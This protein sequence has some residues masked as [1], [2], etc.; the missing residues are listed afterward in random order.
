MQKK[1]SKILSALL[2]VFLLLSMMPTQVFAATENPWNSSSRTDNVFLDA[3]KYLGYNTTR[4]TQYNEVGGDVA[5]SNRT[6]IG[7]NTGGATG[8]ETSAGLP[9]IATFKSKGLCCGSYA[10]YVYFNYLPNVAKVD[11]KKFT[12]PSNPRSTTSWHEACEKWVTAGN[13]KKTTFNASCSSIS[14][15]S[16][17]QSLP[18]GTLLIFKDS[19]GAYLHT[20]IYAG[21]RTT[22]NYT[23]YYQTHVGN[24]R[25]PEVCLIN[26][27]NKDGK[28]ATLEATYT[29]DIP[30]EYF[31]AVGIKKVDDLGKAVSG[32]KIGLYSD[33]GCTKLVTTLT[34]GSDG[35]ATY[36]YSNG[37][38]TLEEG[39]TYYFKEISAPSGYDISTTVVSVKV[40]KEKITYA[41]TSIVDNRQGKITLTKYDDAGTKLGAGYVFG[42]YSDK[43]CTKQV[44]T[45]TT[46]ANSVATS[47]Y[48]SAG[49]YY[50][51]EK[52]LPSSDKTHT[53]NSTVYTVTVTKGGTTAVNN[54]RFVNDRMKG[55][56][57]IVKTSPDGN[58]EG[59]G[60]TVTGNGVNQT[61]KTGADGTITLSNLTAGTYTVKENV[62]EGYICK[63]ATKTVTVSPGATATVTFENR[64]IF[65]NI[66]LTKVDAE[67][68]D[69]KLSGAEFTVTIKKDGKTTTQKMMEVSKGVYRL[70]N[71][72][73]GSVCTVKE[74]V[75]PEGFVLSDET[76]TVT[77]KEE[78]TYT[79]NSAGFGC[80]INR[81]IKGSLKIVKVDSF[82]KTPLEDVG[83][84]L[85]DSSG[86]QIKEGYTD[87]N[88]EL[89]FENLRYGN[90]TYQEFKALEGFVLDETVYD[91]SITTDG[92]IISVQRENEAI[93]GSIHI[94][95]T[96]VV[97]TKLSDVSF[98]LEYS[99]DGGTTYQPV[100]SRN[101]TDA[102]SIGGCTSEGLQNGILVTDENGEAWF[103]GLRISTQTG[104][105]LYR[106]TETETKDGYQLLTDYA[107]EG[108]LTEDGDI[109]VEFTVVNARIFELPAT[110][111][112][113]FSFLIMIGLLSAL[114]AFW[115]GYKALKNEKKKNERT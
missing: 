27:F 61:V 93:Q 65:G 29:P 46:N 76:F 82:D 7:Y 77:I 31:G 55:A 30:E 110:G 36:G 92:Q 59:I 72:A 8:L 106:V 1:F 88:G 90:Y 114:I 64:P 45:M 25:G 54:G 113:G 69:N 18:I 57:K 107:Y 4:F 40:I 86:T 47:G 75:A 33:S 111:G 32:A 95:K 11:M 51:K 3:L 21:Y 84:R 41:S 12:Q 101:E 94:Y 50:V 48:L 58:V 52:S 83:Y 35:T 105:I 13:A 89:D 24:S 108:E 15:L 14:S 115:L 102:V 28:A 99:T 44:T 37:K 38:Y 96:D 71:I 68:P 81:P 97:G 56:I 100:F 85:Y 62:P 87:K 66:E 43:A 2:A 103:N 6:T 9:D 42:I 67:Y 20:G 80:V 112:Y 63:Q 34:T 98:L 10:A 39:S 70:E 5:A 91:F 109:D 26:N 78:K 60:M 19:S 104:K 23:Y 53:M 74:S 73:Y 49:T 16:K 79:V 17:L 22:G